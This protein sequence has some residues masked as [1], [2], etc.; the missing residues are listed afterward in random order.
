MKLS[1][2]V[3]MMFL[4]L[5]VSAQKAK[6]TVSK[7]IIGT[8]TEPGKSE[9]LY[10]Y[11]FNSVTGD[12]TY[13]AKAVGVVNPSYLVISNDQRY[14][15]AV[16]ETGRETPGG[17]T[18]FEFDNQSGALKFLNKVKSMGDDPC[19]ISIDQK[20]RLVF[21]GNYSGG[22]LSAF[23][24]QANG[25]LS[26]AVQ[27]IQHEGSSVNKSRQEK[28]HVH[29][30]VISPDKKF[31]LTADLGTDKINVYRIRDHKQILSDHDAYSVAAGSGPRHLTFHPNGKIVYLVHEITGEVSVYQYRKGHLTAIQTVSMLAPG[32]KG[33][34]GAADIHV[35]PDGKYLYASNRGDANEIVIY[36]IVKDDKIT[37][38]G[39]QSTLGKGPRNFAID[40][41]GDFLFVAN[42]N[43]DEIVVFK[44]NGITGMLSDTGKRINVGKPVCLK[45]AAL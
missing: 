34:I 11:E 5:M 15:Y 14:V 18:S 40:P 8:Y 31:L 26:D 25:S 1:A 41:S 24:V 4:P 19:Y 39:R 9:G 32:F 23:R 10:V 7:L 28:P 33:D 37:L 3:I 27:V 20:G 17:V 30:T 2:I 36:S 21:V 43:S 29:A 35:S 6:S 42:Q 16:N 13:K 38:A 22:N 45:F 12:L 44:R